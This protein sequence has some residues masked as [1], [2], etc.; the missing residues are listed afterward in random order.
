MASLSGFWP[1]GHTEPS[2]ADQGAQGLNPRSKGL[3]SKADTTLHQLIDQNLAEA[4]RFLNQHGPHR[5]TAIFSFE[6]QNLLNAVLCDRENPTA[7]LLPG[8][9]PIIESYCSFVLNTRN[10][11]VVLDS[12]IDPRVAGHP[13]QK[14]FRAY[15]GVP[16]LNPDGSVWGS[17]CYFD[18]EPQAVSAR[19]FALLEQAAVLLRSSVAES[20]LVS[21]S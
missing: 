1:A 2:D 10:S 13:K 14:V 3:L 7:E 16:I 20:S 17:I 12:L 6:N 19:Q 21:S 15:C 11:F 9:V 5:Y 18:T 4:L 8:L